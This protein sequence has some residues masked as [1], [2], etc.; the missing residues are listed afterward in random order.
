MELHRGLGYKYRGIE[1]DHPMLSGT[2]VTE[3]WMLA[4]LGRHIRYMRYNR[5]R[6]VGRHG[7]SRAAPVYGSGHPHFRSEASKAYRQ[8]IKPQYRPGAFWTLP[9]GI[10]EIAVIISGSS[11]GRALGC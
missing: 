1:T 5:K 6:D 9:A 7:I 2:A 10:S 8:K 3:G 4:P 11:V